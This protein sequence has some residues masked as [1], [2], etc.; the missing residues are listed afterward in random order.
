MIYP[1]FFDPLIEKRFVSLFE[2]KD[3]I[4][5]YRSQ[6]AVDGVSLKL[7]AGSSLGLIGA[8]GAGKTSTLKALLGLMKYQ[9]NIEVFGQRP[10]NLKVFTRLGFAPEDADPPEY[11][12]TQE[13]LRYVASLRIKD[14]TSRKHEVEESLKFFELDPKKAIRNC[15]KGQKRRVLIAQAMLGN[16]DLLILDEPLNGL[17]PMFMIKL[18]ERLIQYREKGKSIVYSS[19]ILSE[20]EKSCTDLV[21]LHKGKLLYSETV[22][23]AAAE[24]G[25]VENAFAKKVGEAGA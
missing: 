2:I 24:F 7:E 15:S 19:H 6:V 5:K 3:L 21:I 18:R 1:P 10:G 25:S 11:L 9:G 20:I 17:D 12:T 23:K 14:S 8:N 22:A 13:Y 16:P 4:V